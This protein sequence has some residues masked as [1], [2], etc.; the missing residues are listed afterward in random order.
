MYKKQSL[1]WD[2]ALV[3]GS[4]LSIVTSKEELSIAEEFLNHNKQ[5]QIVASGT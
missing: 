5:Q 2:R 3:S 1:Y 4:V